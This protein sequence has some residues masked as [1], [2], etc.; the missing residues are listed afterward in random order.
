[1][2]ALLLGLFLWSSPS[3]VI[4]DGGL[5]FE[6]FTKPESNWTTPTRRY[7]DFE[8]TVEQVVEVFRRASLI[9]TLNV[10]N[11]RLKIDDPRTEAIVLEV[12][13]HQLPLRSVYNYAM[14]L[15]PLPWWLAKLDLTI[16]QVYRKLPRLSDAEILL[17][18]QSI[19]DAN[20]SL[21]VEVM[22]SSTD[23]LYTRILSEALGKH[24]TPGYLYSSTRNGT[25]TWTQWIEKPRAAPLLRIERPE[26]TDDLVIQSIVQLNIVG[27][28]TTRAGIQS[29][30]QATAMQ[31]L[32]QFVTGYP[33]RPG[34]IFGHV[35]T[36]TDTS[37]RWYREQARVRQS[38]AGL[39]FAAALFHPTP[40]GVFEPKRLISYEKLEELA[41]LLENFKVSLPREEQTIFTQTIDYFASAK[42]YDATRIK[43][44][45]QVR[46]TEAS[47][48]D[49]V[50]LMQRAAQ[51]AQIAEWWQIEIF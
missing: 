11:L 1:M 16:E 13:G 21:K 17:G 4:A 7:R 34:N 20:L 23:E 46:K 50:S 5:C 18:I 36:N 42:M 31:P 48:E 6:I 22:K 19:K 9:T 24:V 2:R 39:Y 10:R 35:R 3:L 37:W 41:G 30:L 29:A 38:Q 51:N 44:Y 40:R 28:D 15:H 25:K 45:L 32:L 49:I 8:P 43:E 47:T 12:T 14:T 33:F 27:F 26:L